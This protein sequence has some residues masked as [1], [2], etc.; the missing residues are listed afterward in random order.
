MTGYSKSAVAPYNSLASK[1]FVAVSPDP[2]WL[3]YTLGYFDTVFDPGA[4][5]LWIWSASTSAGTFPR[6]A[7]YCLKSSK[8]DSWTWLIKTL[9]TNVWTSCC[10]QRLRATGP[11]QI[12]WFLWIRYITVIAIKSKGRSKSVHTRSLCWASEFRLLCRN[13]P[14]SMSNDENPSNRWCSFLLEL[15]SVLIVFPLF[16]IG[17]SL[18]RLEDPSTRS[19]VWEIWRI[20]EWKALSSK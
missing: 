14:L 1:V 5:A 7:I 12:G 18:T 20:V 3:W 16:W 15:L 11:N 6:L 10:R 13:C 4:G 19:Y 17:V 8:L 9:W 2:S